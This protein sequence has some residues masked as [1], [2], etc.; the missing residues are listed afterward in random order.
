MFD[1]IKKALE[2][3]SSDGSIYLVHKLSNNSGFFMTNKHLLYMVYNFEHTPH[4]S[5]TTEFLRL[6]T[7]VEIVSIKNNQMFS[8]GRYNVLEILP[9][10]NLYENSHLESFIKLC[11]A[12][13]EFMEAKKFV[14]FFY[15]L[16]NL[17]QIPKEQQ[18]KNLVG[19][20]GELIFMDCMCKNLGV[21]LST[22]WHKTGS[23]DKYE[24][25]L[26]TKNLEVKTTA[27]LDEEVTIKHS[28]LFNGEC[29]YLIAVCLEESNSGKTLNQLINEMQEDPQYYN[30]YNFALNIEREKKKI[31]STDADIKRFS[32]KSIMVYYADDINPFNEIPESVSYLTYKLALNQKKYIPQDNWGKEFNDV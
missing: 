10:E 32:V 31:S 1:K 30:N 27:S 2:S 7:N 15:S 9:V 20:F 13:S 22:C 21:D 3:C 24:F 16:A 6:N 18:Y 11:K 14:K 28:Q 5:L 19:L 23:R 29:N 17:F 25:V 26:K 8:T 12:H 4:Q